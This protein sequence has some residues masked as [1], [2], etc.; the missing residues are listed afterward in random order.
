MLQKFSNQNLRVIVVWEPI[1]PT[2]WR[3]PTT[4]TLS[5][6][7]DP[8]AEQ[9]WDPRHLVSQEIERSLAANHVSFHG[10]ASGGDLWDLAV[11]YSPAASFGDALPSPAFIDGPVVDVVE[12][13]SR[14][15]QQLSSHAA[16]DA[17]LQSDFAWGL[18]SWSR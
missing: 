18:I 12:P 9:F 1:L 2:D 14:T 6:V 3:R 11:L 17:E 8:R 7:A 15:M 10:H 5:R 13:L 16:G 4:G